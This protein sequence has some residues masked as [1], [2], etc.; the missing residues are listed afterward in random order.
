MPNATIGTGSFGTNYWQ[1]DASMHQAWHG[2]YGIAY[3]IGRMIQVDCFFASFATNT[4][5]AVAWLNTNSAVLYTAQSITAGNQGSGGGGGWYA[6][7]G[8]VPC[9]ILD[10]WDF[11]HYVSGGV[12]II[13]RTGAPDGWVKASAITPSS[14]GITFTNNDGA[15]WVGATMPTYGTYF[16]IEHYVRVGGVMKRTFRRVK[17]AGAMKIVTRYVKVGGVWKR[18]AR[19]AENVPFEPHAEY[20]CWAKDANGIWTPGLL[21]WEG[22]FYLGPDVE[23]ARRMQLW[24]RTHKAEMRQAYEMRRAA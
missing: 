10:A 8:D 18:V 11:G 5:G 2:T 7:G 3:N 19:L 15:P 16:I 12:F 1:W 14:G 20:D 13:C 4:G 17:V 23:W 21:R 24:P 6:S 9:G 22:P